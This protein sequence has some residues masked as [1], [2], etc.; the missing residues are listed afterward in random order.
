MQEIVFERG[1]IKIC[2]HSFIRKGVF[3]ECV[4]CFAGYFDPQNKFPVQE[5][6]NY[7]KQ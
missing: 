4:K 5:I 2:N 1:E 6:N 3:V 7:F